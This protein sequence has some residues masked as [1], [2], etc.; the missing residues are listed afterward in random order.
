M[1]RN[2]G[3]EARISEEE[4][5]FIIMMDLGE[6]PPI[7]TRT[8]LRGQTLHM[9]IIAQTIEDPLI[10]A[11]ISHLIETMEIDREM[12]PLGTRMET[13]D[14]MESFLVLRP[15]KDETTHQTTIA[16]QEMINLLNLRSADLT[17]DQR[18]VSHPMNKNSRQTII[19]HLMWSALPQPTM[20][21]MKYQ[22]FVR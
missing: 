5:T 22:I 16:N 21:L 20:P 1:D 4:T 11:Q 15:L 18:L 12:G 19:K 7:I 13:G 6:F 9:G 17:I 3:L 8:F 14:Q 10:N 2:N